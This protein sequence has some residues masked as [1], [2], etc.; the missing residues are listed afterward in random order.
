MRFTEDQLNEI[1]KKGNVKIATTGNGTG[2]CSE[3]QKQQTDSKDGERKRSQANSHHQP[4]EE[5]TDECDDPQ[6]RVAI[7][8]LFSDERNRDG[9]GAASTIID[10]LISAAGRL[11]QVDSR[12]LR[13]FADGFKAERRRN[14]NNRK[15]KKTNKT[16]IRRNKN[17]NDKRQSNL[18]I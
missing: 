5:K 10:C 15:V 3:L 4:Q 18:G 12:T 1:L 7:K 16:T 11:A 17:G 2:A 9:D 13:K 8:I 6:F 14:R